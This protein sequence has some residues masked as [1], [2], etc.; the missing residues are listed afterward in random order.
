LENFRAGAV[1]GVA[2]DIKSK[3]LES[4]LESMFTFGI[5]RSGAPA[6]HAHVGGW[7]L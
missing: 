3:L 1:E 7:G 5:R 4:Q 2:T 6:K